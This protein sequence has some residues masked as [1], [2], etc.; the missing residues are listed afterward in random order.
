MLHIT[1]PLST[2]DRGLRPDTTEARP[3]AAVEISVKGKHQHVNIDLKGAIAGENTPAF[4][5]FL[6]AVS[7]FVG[8]HWTL[9]M[10]DLRV[11]SLQGICHLVQF[12]E[13]L[14]Q[15]GYQLEICS[16]HRNV[17]ATLQELN[18]VHTFAWAD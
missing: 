15:R 7:S 4:L 5:E 13:F 10:K 6:K 12:A 2:S 3:V 1:M 11:L 14:H 9:Q 17:Y 18:L 16:V 8:T